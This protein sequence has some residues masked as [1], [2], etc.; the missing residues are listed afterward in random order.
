M[1]G[2]QEWEKSDLIDCVVLTAAGPK[3]FCAGGDVATLARQNMLGKQG[4]K[5]STE[6]F[7]T[8]YKLNHLI[9]TYAK[10]YIAIIDG[11]TM[12]G[13]MGLSCHGPF[14]VATEK[15]LF[16]MPETDIGL[17]PDVGGGFFLSRLDGGLGA[18][19][20]ITSDRVAGIQTYY[21][22]IATHYIHSSNIPDL[23]NQLTSGSIHFPRG[24]TYQQRLKVIDNA[25]IKLSSTTPHSDP[26]QLAGEKREA[27]DEVFG[28]DSTIPEILKRLADISA[29]QTRF[30][31]DSVREWAKKT[32]K[33]IT[34][35]RSPTSMAVTLRQLRLARGWTIGET[36]RREHVIAAR[37]MRHADFVNGVKSKLID[38]PAT[39]PKWN[40]PQPEQVTDAMVDEFFNAPKDLPSLVLLDEESRA[41]Y[42]EYPHAWTALP[43]EARIK[44][45]LRSAGAQNPPGKTTDQVVGELAGSIGNRPGAEKKVLDVWARMARSAA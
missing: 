24:S 14:R 8:E 19:L 30:S 43:S 39:A 32:H 20:A 17:F 9:A 28:P 2:L 22:G 34:T 40:P 15:T 27:I 45:M 4:E 6:Y 21:A 13:G 26:V 42:R 10:P 25:L 36:F 29:G 18:Y 38:K 37:F 23:I 35:G 33:V 44:G 1:T 16:A 41:E 11:I 12:G 3:A 31:S 5:E 7:A